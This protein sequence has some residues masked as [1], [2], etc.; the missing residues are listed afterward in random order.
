MHLL[1]GLELCVA[2]GGF[3]LIV[4]HLPLSDECWGQS[5]CHPD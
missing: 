5:P 2:Q 1:A 3:K 4:F